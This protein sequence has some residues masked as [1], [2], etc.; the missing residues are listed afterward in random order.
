MKLIAVAL[1]CLLVAGMWLQDVNSWSSE[2][3]WSHWGFSSGRADAPS[4]APGLGG[5]AHPELTASV[6][7]ALARMPPEEEAWGT[8]V[9]WGHRAYRRTVSLGSPRQLSRQLQ[10]KEAL[11]PS[12]PAAARGELCG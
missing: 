12:A 7:P 3:G 11:P 9:G 1:V 8:W 2:W 5:R 4:G 10:Q 6:S